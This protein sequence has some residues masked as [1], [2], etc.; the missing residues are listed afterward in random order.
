MGT[1]SAGLCLLT[2]QE[3]AC[4]HSYSPSPALTKLWNHYLTFG[5]RWNL[6]PNLVRSYQTFG[7]QET[8]EFRSNT[9]GVRGYLEDLAPVNSHPLLVQLHF[10]ALYI[11]ALWKISFE[12]R[13][14]LIR[15]VKI[16]GTVI[17]EE[18]APIEVMTCLKWRNVWFLVW[19]TGMSQAFLLYI[20]LVV[21]EIL[22]N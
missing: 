10:F 17:A 16:M 14:D 4:H 18:A 8:P 15:K 20:F 2:Y 3:S 22:V 7:F 5:A 13:V 11:Q 6:G 1:C 12:N 19:P 9:L 21:T